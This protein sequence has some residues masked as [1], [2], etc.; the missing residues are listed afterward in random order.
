MLVVDPALGRELGSAG[1]WLLLQIES[2]RRGCGVLLKHQ[3][4]GTVDEMRRRLLGVAVESSPVLGGAAAVAA[5]ER[6]HEIV[7]HDELD[8]AHAFQG[9]AAGAGN[10]AVLKQGAVQMLAKFGSKIR[11][12]TP[13]PNIAGK[14]ARA[15]EAARR[16]WEEQAV[17]VDTAIAQPS[18]VRLK[19]TADSCD[20]C[21]S[22]LGQLARVQ[23][24]SVGAHAAAESLVELVLRSRRASHCRRRRR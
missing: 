10:R 6:L 13:G 17:A 15:E 20:A 1:F 11:G 18:Q 19:T 4:E 9:W 16:W 8:P 5:V 2:L 24:T 3:A 23:R 22:V 21:R 12:A 7:G 14:D